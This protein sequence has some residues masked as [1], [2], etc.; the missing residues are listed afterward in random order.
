MNEKTNQQNMFE[1][2]SFT[3]GTKMNKVLTAFCAIV[4]VLVTELLLGFYLYSYVN[5]N[6]VS[7]MELNDILSRY[8][9]NG[10]ISELEFIA[11][12][13]RSAENVST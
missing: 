8:S 5:Q 6:F 3:N 1:K 4:F 9:T 11:K 13:K 7:I 12:V 10:D 2:K